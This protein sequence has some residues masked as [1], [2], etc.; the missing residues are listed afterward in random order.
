MNTFDDLEKINVK[1][2]DL[3]RKAV[4]LK[5]QEEYYK[6]PNSRAGQ[7]KERVD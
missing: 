4:K 7:K 1:A 2:N 5:G 6:I 3:L